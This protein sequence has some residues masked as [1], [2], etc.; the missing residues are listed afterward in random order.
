MKTN[1]R[2]EHLRRLQLKIPFSVTWPPWRH[3]KTTD[4]HGSVTTWTKLNRKWSGKSVL[5]HAERVCCSC[6]QWKVDKGV[7]FPCFSLNFVFKWSQKTTVANGNESMR[8]KWEPKHHDVVCSK[9]FQKNA[10][11]IAPCW[12]FSL[13]SNT[14]P[15]GNRLGK[16]SNS[17]LQIMC[18]YAHY[19]T[20][21]SRCKMA[22][23]HRVTD[24]EKKNPVRI[25]K[26]ET[27]TS[28]SVVGPLFI[29]PLSFHLSRALLGAWRFVLF[30]CVY[31]SFHNR[32]DLIRQP[33]FYL[34]FYFISPIY[35][36]LF[37][38]T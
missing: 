4:P 37:H 15:Q 10:S 1:R 38:H 24:L 29:S 14:C 28:L 8:K 22:S 20:L 17:N 19:V 36:C 33:A 12:A 11:Q 25:S 13:D 2:F 7:F 9:H 34:V 18:T 26:D 32:L 21:G 23:S 6:L 16:I 5:K 3:N 31:S 30:P 35:P 27:P